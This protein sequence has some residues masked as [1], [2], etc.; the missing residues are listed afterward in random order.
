MF[1]ADIDDDEVS[2]LTSSTRSHTAYAMLTAESVAKFMKSVNRIR[3]NSLTSRK[4]VEKLTKLGSKTKSLS[5]PLLPKIDTTMEEEEELSRSA[6][7]TFE[8]K[9]S[10]EMNFGQKTVETDIGIKKSSEED[11]NLSVTSTGSAVTI[12]TKQ[13]TSVTIATS[14]PTSSLNITKC[15]MYAD[16]VSAS[17]EEKEDDFVKVF[18][19]LLN[20]TSVSVCQRCQSYI[21]SGENTHLGKYFETPG[22]L[23]LKH[24]FNPISFRKAKIVYNFGLSE[25]NRVKLRAVCMGL[26]KIIGLKCLV[27]WALW[28]L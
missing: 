20:P 4:S 3:F 22:A 27:K 9:S 18:R 25:C 14:E 1:F 26:T 13:E 2:E 6:S 12:T 28:S 8:N 16:S 17:K 21:P 15:P 23:F 10:L 19:L 7:T 24:L 11:P 5:C